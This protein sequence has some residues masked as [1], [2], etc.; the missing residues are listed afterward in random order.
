LK[1]SAYKQSGYI[2]EISVENRKRISRHIQFPDLFAAQYHYSATFN[3]YSSLPELELV[4]MK[5]VSLLTISLVQ[6][7]D[8]C[9]I[10]FERLSM[11]DFSHWLGFY[12]QKKNT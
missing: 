8:T 10:S 12:F 4:G 1:T 3:L 5:S 2:N 9:K 11:C 7:P 6:R